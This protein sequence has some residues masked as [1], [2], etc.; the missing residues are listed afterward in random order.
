M[1]TKLSTYLRPSTRRRAAHDELVLD[2]VGA[3]TEAFFGLRALAHTTGP[4][5]PLGG[6]WWAELNR[7]KQAGPQTVPQLAAHR[8]VTRQGMQKLIDQMATEGH[9]EYRSN[10]AH[11]RSK[12]VV[13]A[14]KGEAALAEMAVAIRSVAAHAMRDVGAEDLAGAVTVLRA[15]RE[16]LTVFDGRMAAPGPPASSRV[17]RSPARKTGARASRRVAGQSP[18][19]RRGA[20]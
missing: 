20:E 17:S 10:P 4:V 3:T 9:V 11:A 1:T 18:S 12:L 15:L 13:L 16:G 19:A 7:L 8:A 6:G 2:L 14:S 5:L